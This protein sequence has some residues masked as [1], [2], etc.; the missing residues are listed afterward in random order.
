MRRL[1]LAVLTA[2]VLALPAGSLAASIHGTARSERIR[3]TAKADRIDVV[4]GGVD[5]VSCGAGVDVVEADASDRI[6]AD[7][8]IVSRRI[9]TDTIA[10]PIGQHE[11]EV[12]PN[13]FGWGASV[14]ASFQVGRIVDGGAAGIGW[15]TSADSGRT[16]HAGL[17]PGVTTSTGGDARRASDPAVAFDAAHGV[18]L[19]ATLI[20]GDTFTSLGINRST[21]GTTWSQPVSA[22]RF[23]SSGLAYD[24]EWISCDNTS[25]SPFYGSCYLVW[26]DEIGLRLAS[27]TSHDGGVTWS[28]PVTITAQSGAGAEGALPLI[29]PN[30]NVTVVYNGD[31]NGIFAVR[32]T[33]GGVTFGTPV[34]I[35]PLTQALQPALRTPS[36]PTATVDSTGRIYVAWADCKLRPSCIGDDIV[37]SSSVDGVAWTTLSRLPGAGFDSFVPGIAADPSTPG[38]LSFVTYVRTASTCAAALCAFGVAVSSSHDGGATWSKAERLDALSPRYTWL[39]STDGGFFVGDY[40]GATFSNGRFVPVFALAEAPSG[41]TKH[42]AMFAASLP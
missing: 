37:L 4:G 34:G 40:V 39:A 29:Q 18:W 23:D 14:V 15:S 41:T 5:S 3:G 17:L 20:V 19:V 27:Q 13:V 42:E 25:T 1:P 35:A 6:G 33:D 26:T 31:D 8:E 32:S 12:E 10:G 2:L 38:R 11:T 28:A 16:W 22:D 7:C 9:S 24:K 30:G 36:L 21:D